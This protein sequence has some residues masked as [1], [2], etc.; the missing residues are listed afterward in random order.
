MT[1]Y[2]YQYPFQSEEDPQSS[3]VTWVLVVL[4][5]L[6]VIVLIFFA[7]RDLAAPGGLFSP[8]GAS[9]FTANPELSLWRRYQGERQQT[10]AIFAGQN[11]L[12]RFQYT[13]DPEYGRM[14]SLFLAQNPEISLY[15][16]Y[17]ADLR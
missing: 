11:L 12:D 8:A 16:R 9:A 14:D 10:M 3:R 5:V 4:L 13:V 15:R 6:L 17:R 7:P 1:R 2:P